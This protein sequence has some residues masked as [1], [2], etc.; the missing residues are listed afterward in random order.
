MLFR[1]EYSQADL[2]KKV[3][4]DMLSALG[5]EDTF[6]KVPWPLPNMVE[7]TE[8]VFWDYRTTMSFKGELWCGQEKYIDD[9]WGHLLVYFADAYN[10]QNGG[11]AVAVIRNGYPK[12]SD[13]RYYEWSA[14]KHDFRSKNIGNCLNRYTCT[15]CGVSHD[16]DSSG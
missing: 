16:I 9:R 7:S 8:D 5:L 15:K 4:K 14:C 3:E 13:V 6:Q 1:C 12:P 2:R 11:F 10:R